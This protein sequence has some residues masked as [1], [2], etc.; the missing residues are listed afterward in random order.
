MYR[1]YLLNILCNISGIIVKVNF[2]ININHPE[3]AKVTSIE[4]TPVYVDR[5][6]ESNDKNIE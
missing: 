3:K 4:Y 5:N 2:K 6:R 1:V